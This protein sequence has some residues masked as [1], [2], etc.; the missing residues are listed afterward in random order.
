M[1]QLKSGAFF[2]PCALLIWI[3]D[4]HLETFLDNSR[5][6]V[7]F[8]FRTW[9]RLYYINIMDFLERLVGDVDKH[10]RKITIFLIVLIMFFIGF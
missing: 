1:H 5:K 9:Q 10:S 8:L 2:K 6:G 7:I 4:R 3:H